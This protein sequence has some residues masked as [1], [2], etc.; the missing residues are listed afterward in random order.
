MQNFKR[1]SATLLA[2][3][4]LASTFA[5]CDASEAPSSSSTAPVVTEDGKEMVG[6]IYVEGLPIAAEPVTYKIMNTLAAT[7]KS[8]GQNNKDIMKLASEGTNV[9]IEWTETSEA[10]M[11][12][13]VKL[14]LATGDGL[15]DAFRTSHITENSIAENPGNFWSIDDE[16]FM[17][18]APNIYEQM[19]ANVDEGIDALRKADGQIYSLPS[20]VWSEYAN[21]ATAIPYIRTGWMDDLGL[22]MPSTMDELYEVLLAF[23]TEDPNGNGTADEIP[24]LFAQ[25]NWAAKIQIMAGSYG[26]AG[27]NLNNDQWF[28]RVENGEYKLNITEDRFRAFLE[29]MNRWHQA[30]LLNIDGFSLTGPEFNS[31]NGQDLQGLYGTWTPDVDE[32]YA[33]E[34]AALP[35]LT[36]EGYEDV[37]MKA[38]ELNTR[39]AQ[40]NTFIITS[41]CEEPEGLL[42]WWDNI[43]SNTEWKLISRD[44]PEGIAWEYGDDGL[45]YVKGVDPYPDGLTTETEVHNTLA[46]R[47]MSAVLFGDETA[48][49]NPASPSS[50]LIRY[51]V[52]PYYEDYFPE[53]HIPITPIPAEPAADF[54]FTKSEI[55]TVVQNYMADAVTNGVTDDNWAK[56]QSDL[57]AYNIEEWQTFYQCYVSNDWTNW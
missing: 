13:Q 20:A 32:Y 3:A 44:G 46:W 8:G 56:F 48:K 45:A 30:G 34:W 51:E 35:V 10:A 40:M 14:I 39:T 27:R 1:I 36:A 21:W 16:T 42:R 12:D 22:E 2:V 49:P 15:P 53:E 25:N 19:E 28:G 41:A 31:L 6:N 33:G 4:M 47:S 5:A 55:E 54:A 18:F 7:D 24:F 52:G 17:K 29:E 11:A 37:A 57:V 23:K 26:M 50:D 38:G 43:H 9:T